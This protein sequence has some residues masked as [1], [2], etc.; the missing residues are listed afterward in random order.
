M[1]LRS[2]GRP[3][4]AALTASS[5]VPRPR[6]DLLFPAFPPQLDGI[7]HHTAFLAEALSSYADVRVLTAEKNPE[8][9]GP[10][11]AV[12]AFDSYPLH[13]ILK[14]SSEL[15]NDPPDWL[16][17][18]YNPFSY[19]R[20]G[21]NPFLPYLLWTIRQQPNAPRIALIVHE[22]FVPGSRWQEYPM[23]IWQRSQLWTLGRLSDAIFFSIAP[24][25]TT[26]QSWFPDTPVNHLPVSS[27]IP[28]KPVTSKRARAKRAIAESTFVLG[29]FGNAH[30]SRL[31]YFVRAAAEKIQEQM[32][33]MCVLYVGAAGEAVRSALPTVPVIDAGPLPAEGVSTC[34]A[35]MNLYLAPFRKGVSSRRGSF[36]TGIQ[37]GIPTLSTVG[38]HTDAFLLDENGRSFR[39]TSDADPAEFARAALELTT[40]PAQRTRMSHSAEHFFQSHFAWDRLARRLLSFLGATIPDFPRRRI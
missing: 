13:S 28:R 1:P 5:S 6:V 11:D 2:Y 19:G 15:R 17:V 10:V 37:H 34:F 27:N 30:P 3:N 35:C 39:L 23:A 18:Q 31:L 24:W 20:W 25:A 12:T 33:S 4:D 8:P 36:M 32:P 21:F 26:F 16:L 29:L 7:G 9:R 38:I 22:P 40:N 14:V